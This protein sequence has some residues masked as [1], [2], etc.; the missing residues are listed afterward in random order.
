MWTMNRPWWG[1]EPKQGGNARRRSYRRPKYNVPVNIIEHEDSFEL[2]V[3]AVS[4][5]KEGI[6]V[7][8]VEDTLYLSGTRTPAGDHSPNFLLQE[9]PIKS[10]ERSFELSHRVDKGAIKA[11][12]EHGVLVVTVPKTR[13]A[14]QPEQE[15]PVE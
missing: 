3:H 5:P 9:Y 13:A 14:M 2:R 4:F 1:E 11:T 7:A 10:F 15:I 8:V 6:K 12:H